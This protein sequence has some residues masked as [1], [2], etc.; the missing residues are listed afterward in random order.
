MGKRGVH[1]GTIFK[2]PNGTWGAALQVDGRRKFVYAKT[3]KEVQ[4][5]LHVLQL[6]REAGLFAP[7]VSVAALKLDTMEAFLEYWLQAVMKRSVRPN[8]W[9]HYALCVRRMLPYLGKVKVEALNA[10]HIRAMEARMLDEDR[11][12]ART[13]RHCHAVLH[14]AMNEAVV[15]GLVARNPVGDL[16]P[17]RVERHEMHTLG[18][19]EVQRLLKIANGTRWHALWTVLVTTG[20]RL[21]EATALRWSDLDLS[22]GSAVIQRSVQRQRQRGMVFTEPKTRSSRRTVLLPPG[23]VTVLAEHRPIVEEQRDAAGSLW[24][25]FDLVFPSLTGAPLDPARVNQALHTDLHKAGLPRIRVHDLRHTAA[26]LLLEEGTHPKI[27]QDLLGHSSIALT[28]DLYSH[29]TPRL[30][31]EAVLR[32]QDMLFEAKDVGDLPKRGSRR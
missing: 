27:V 13:V 32:M 24:Q 3:R 11:Y 5:K 31:D 9:E 8:T 28:L 19:E 2:R 10:G 6:K 17:P 29:V 23:A 1:E 4:E 26:T 22:K 21:G 15:S 16:S 25:D 20:L 12:A 30:Q 14:N 18:R 7:A